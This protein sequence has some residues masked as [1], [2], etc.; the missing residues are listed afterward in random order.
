MG[1]QQTASAFK[2]FRTLR[3]H[4]EENVPLSKIA[5]INM[6]SLSTLKRW[7]KDYKEHGLAGLERKQRRDKGE[8]KILSPEMEKLVEALRLAR[9]S[10]TIAAIH[11]KVAQIVK[12]MGCVSPSYRVVRD[13]VQKVDPALL[14]LAH[15]GNKAYDQKYELIYRREASAPNEMWQA[16]HTPL[17]IVLINGNGDSKKPWLT[18]IID[19]FSRAIS[20]Y[21]LSF[22]SPCSINT[23]L[24]LHQAIWRKK[25]S[26]WQVCGIP[27]IFYTDNGS[28]FK[29]DHIRHV[30]ADLKMQLKFSIPGKPQGR[31]RIERFFLTVNQLLLMNLPGYCPP[32]TIYPEATLT[33]KEFIPLFERFVVD[34]YHQRNHTGIGMAPIDRWLGRGF[35]P[36]LPESLEQLDL[37]LLTVVKTRKVRRD[38]IHF[39]TMRYIE[40]TLAS[41]VGEDVIIRY[42]PRDLGEIR[43]FYDNAFLCRAICHELADRS[44]SLKEI[45]RARQQR[46]RKLRKVIS[47]RKSLMDILLES[48]VKKT[49][50]RETVKQVYRPPDRKHKLKLY[51]ND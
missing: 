37:L 43:V 12:K 34:E 28:D 2:K 10:S 46:K 32:K 38:G 47:E 14:L 26:K 3:P 48:P 7:S 27:A 51:D 41:Y 17:D 35:L 42:D 5:E 18:S 6:I 49:M 23:A 40:P 29:S 19:D 33:L 16:D 21:Y 9:P 45:I 25:D 13:I 4:F 24:A 44:V 50:R 20:G 1:R 11:R 36:R 30:A 39:Q 8:R 15:E 31:G 22:E